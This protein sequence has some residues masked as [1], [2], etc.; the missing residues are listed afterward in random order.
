MLL[1][2]RAWAPTMALHQAAGGQSSSPSH[3]PGRPFCWHG[4]GAGCPAGLV[5]S[6]LTWV[7][8]RARPVAGHLAMLFSASAPCRH[9]VCP[10]GFADRLRY[11]LTLRS[12]RLMAPCCSWHTDFIPFDRAGVLFGN[13]IQNG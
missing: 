2:E 5:Y 11:W 10:G 9:P 12:L 7:L 6:M 1:L 3:R 8:P 13:P 4:M